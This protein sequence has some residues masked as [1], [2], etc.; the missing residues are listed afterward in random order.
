ML[1]NRVNRK[2]QLRLVAKIIKW[3]FIS[4]VSILLILSVVFQAPWKVIVLFAVFLAALTALPKPARKYFWMSVGAIVIALVIWVLLPDNNE[5][6][7]PYT[8]DDNLAAFEAKYKIPDKEN[9][10][11]IYK[12]IL[13][14]L[15]NNEFD[16]NLP[17]EVL[18]VVYREPWKSKDYPQA[19][20]FVKEN[21]NVIAQLFDAS[22][23]E[24]CLLPIITDMQDY[25]QRHILTASIRR[26]ARL[27]AIS[28]NN[29]IAE[30]R[31]NNALEK[32]NAVHTM[33][34]HENQQPNTIDMITGISLKALSMRGFQRIVIE[35]DVYDE[36]LTR[37][38]KM[39]VKDRFNGR[40]VLPK[41]IDSDKISHI[42]EL[43]R[44]YEINQKSKIRLSRDPWAQFRESLRE[45]FEDSNEPESELNKYY[46]NLLYPSYW[47]SKYLKAWTIWYWFYLSSNPEKAADDAEAAF[48]K[49]YLRV[50][51]D[52]DWDKEPNFIK[53]I[54]GMSK[55][56]YHQ[57]YNL[58]TRL[59]TDKKGVLLLIGVKRYK[60]ITGEWPGSLDGIKELTSEENFIDPM[61]NDSFVYK[62]TEDRFT[63]YSKGKNGID[64][65]GEYSSD[66]PEPAKPD[67]WLI[68]PP[69]TSNCNP[70]ED[71][72][73]DNQ[74]Q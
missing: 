37:I 29:D 27:L 45:R 6:W 1:F 65:D 38:E 74:K 68:W 61:N 32:L 16:V 56:I 9:A 64:E 34:A 19:A 43:S 47:K 53:S 4:I 5:G 13:D 71:D 24:K 44:H 63:L 59:K 67:D 10:A 3:A 36:S 12:N 50:K 14:N 60:N 73:N 28:A 40:T 2:R 58:Y 57:V 54:T 46:R 70:Q 72:P 20:K 8:F 69:K 11:V 31:I 25:D 21:E 35:Q 48:E 26:L 55:Q 66:W 52:Y 49:Y 23:K 41:M 62:L 22:K 39:L 51:D 15:D 30:G 7:R 42:N 18:N 17:H 33:G